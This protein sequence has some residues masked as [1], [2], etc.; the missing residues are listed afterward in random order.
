MWRFHE[1]TPNFSKNDYF[2]FRQHKR[3]TFDS[4]PNFGIWQGI[5][6]TLTGF[7]GGIFSAITGSGVDICSFSILS[8][9][10]RYI[11]Y[12]TKKHIILIKKI[13]FVICRVSE[14]VSTPTSVVLMAINTCI[15][16]WNKFRIFQNYLGI[17]IFSLGQVW[18]NLW[19]CNLLEK[20]KKICHYASC[21]S[22]ILNWLNWASKI[23][24]YFTTKPD[25]QHFSTTKLIDLGYKRL[26]FNQLNWI[27]L[28][29]SYYL[30]WN[31]CIDILEFKKY[32]DQLST[33]AL[34][35]RNATENLENSCF[36]LN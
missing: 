6:L 28:A 2:C 31:K 29:T 27:F 3:R 33:T 24:V 22:I 36:I 30:W 26:G 25:F 35:K 7:L 10:F 34:V 21:F 4:V 18:L 23:H 12:F 20:F 17:L 15:G 11:K 13:F 8:L 1:F 16:K 19:I 9:L 5:V 32:S 14:K